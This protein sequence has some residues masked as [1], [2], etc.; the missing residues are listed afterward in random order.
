[1]Q[2]GATSL[3]TPFTAEQIK[4]ACPAGRTLRMLVE[5]AGEPPQRQVNRFDEVDE[6]GC[7]IESWAERPDGSRT[8][9]ERTDATWVELQMHGSFPADRTEHERVLLTTPLGE[10]LCDRYTVTGEKVMTYWFDVGRPGMPVL[11]EHRTGDDPELTVT[12]LSDEVVS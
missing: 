12:V 6:G 4:H 3:P 1:M 7:V 9:A 11:Y 8:P 10:L 5:Q 2:P